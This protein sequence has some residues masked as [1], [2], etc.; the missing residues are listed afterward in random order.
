MDQYQLLRLM[1]ALRRSTFD[2]VAGAFEDLAPEMADE[3]IVSHRDQEDLLVVGLGGEF[4]ELCAPFCAILED[5]QFQ[6]SINCFW[7]YQSFNPNLSGL[8][9]LVGDNQG[10]ITGERLVHLRGSY[11]ENP[12]SS[13]EQ[14]II[15]ASVLTD[16]EP[17]IS[18]I[19]RTSEVAYC[20]RIELRCLVATKRAVD[21][22]SELIDVYP[23][24][25]VP[26]VP[27]NYWRLE[28]TLDPRPVRLVPR[29]S[30]WLVG[31]QF[32]E[33]RLDKKYGLRP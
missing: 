11:I 3:A 32:P 19:R 27:T 25:V 1:D 13:F 20:Q 18:V 24:A 14:G 21:A 4:E 30:R 33:L 8:G 10:Q 2:D 9:E 28:T 7:P 23:M 15:L 22:V 31:R 17:L 6:L 26:E 5:H 16:A 12:N 29:Q